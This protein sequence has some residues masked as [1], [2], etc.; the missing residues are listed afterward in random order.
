MQYK[1]K[2]ANHCRWCGV[3]NETLRHVVNCGTNG[4]DIENVEE[5]IH[6]TDVHLMKEVAIRIEDFLEKV[7]V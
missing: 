6:G 2:G 5:V 4:R 7:D 1:Y 3:S